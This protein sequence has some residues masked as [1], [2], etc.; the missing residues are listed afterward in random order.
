MDSVVHSAHVTHDPA[1]L[2]ALWAEHPTGCFV[3]RSV[4]DAA[5]D[6]P[7]YAVWVPR[8]AAPPRGRPVIL[9]LHGSGER[10]RDGRRQTLL[11]LGPVLPACDP[12]C[13]AL[14]VFPQAA[15]EEH[16][17]GPAQGR[18]LRV[19]EAAI[20]E[21][22]GDPT[23]VALTGLSLGGNG[24]WHL[25]LAAPSQFRAL[26]VVCGWLE[27]EALPASLRD[28]PDPHRAVA[29]HLR[30]LPVWLFHGALDAVVP[31]AASREMAAALADAGAAVRYTEYPDARHGAWQ[32]AYHEPDLLPWLL[33][34]AERRAEHRS[35]D[36]CAPAS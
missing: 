7:P 22:H 27:V 1:A 31:V 16:W 32:P 2:D 29:E 10:G 8:A 13:S 15:P 11:G 9:A 36:P 18:A 35:S 20:A 6:E 24:A 28:A 34:P 25:A 17:R 26:A 12:P 19:L 14:V 4:P 23:M 21:F 30:G 33:A 3:S 5:P